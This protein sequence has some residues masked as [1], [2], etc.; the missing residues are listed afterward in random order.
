MKK[1]VSAILFA[2]LLLTAVSVFTA[3]KERPQYD[4]NTHHIPDTSTT[5]PEDTTSEDTTDD[6]TTAGDTTT[7]DNDIEFF[8]GTGTGGGVGSH[9]PENDPVHTWGEWVTVGP[10]GRI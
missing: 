3:C 2:T 8:D 7:G 6:T 4:L 1:F 10:D 9:Y 5:V